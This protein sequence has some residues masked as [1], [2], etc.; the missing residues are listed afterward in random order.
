MQKQT[1]EELLVELTRYKQ[2]NV[3]WEQLDEERRKEFAKAFHWF[4]RKG[5]YDYGESELPKIP[6]WPQIF[7]EVGKLLSLRDFR[8]F[9]G[10]L[11]EME[12][13]IEQLNKKVF[14]VTLPKA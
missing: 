6:S 11:S 10:N 9:D 13:A 2:S 3:G 7:V 8:N 5:Q 4:Q 14:E 1:R 12:V